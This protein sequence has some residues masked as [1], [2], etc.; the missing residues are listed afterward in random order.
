MMLRS[1]V[2]QDK[3]MLYAGVVREL[4]RSVEA[5][6][7]R[8]GF[9]EAAEVVRAL[10]NDLRSE[11]L[12]VVSNRVFAFK[13]FVDVSKRRK[14]A[15]TLLA[16][17]HLGHALPSAAYAVNAM[18]TGDIAEFARQD[19]PI[20]VISKKY[21][22]NM[23]GILVPNP[24]FAEGDLRKWTRQSRE[25]KTAA[26]AAP[27]YDRDPRL[28]W[29]GNIGSHGEDCERDSGNY[30][31]FAAVSLSAENASLFDVKC[32]KCRPANDTTCA[33]YD[34]TMRALLKGGI[35]NVQD[36]AWVEARDYVRYRAVLNLPGT[37]SG[38]YSRNLNHLWALGAV[39]AL[40]NTSVVE[41]YYPSLRTGTTHLVLDKTNAAEAM[42]RLRRGLFD[43][44]A[45]LD[46]AKRVRDSLVCGEC[47][48]RY[49]LDMLAAILCRRPPLHWRRLC[50][51][52]R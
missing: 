29:R 50:G 7:Q 34:S 38:G 26:E 48:A 18:S 42:D 40:W 36:P 23:P 21:G 28:F 10:A 19:V 15:A 13:R 1:A 2:G 11:S 32:N 3:A 31:R 41:W 37:T 12:F 45:L 46:G 16:M 9:E 47:Q 8:S 39:V 43:V 44:P 25:L 24:F 30:A 52:P 27:W 51:R 20:A 49:I 33:P 5:Y 35:R 6:P 22:Y 14:H 17:K 4:E